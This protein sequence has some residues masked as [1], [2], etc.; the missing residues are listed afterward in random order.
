MLALEPEGLL[1]ASSGTLG[2]VQMG[3]ISATLTRTVPA[4]WAQ[5]LSP[6][7]HSSDSS[8]CKFSQDLASYSKATVEASGFSNWKLL[9]KPC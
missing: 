7:A 6:A 1:K 5:V 3:P 8:W 9:F 4:R 2:Q